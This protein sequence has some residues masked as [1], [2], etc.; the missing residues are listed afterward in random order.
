MGNVRRGW[1]NNRDRPRNNN[2]GFYEAHNNDVSDGQQRIIDLRDVPS[3]WPTRDG[4]VSPAPDAWRWQD[5]PDVLAAVDS[6][7][8][9]LLFNVQLELDGVRW[10]GRST[11]TRI[12]VLAACQDV[13][14]LWQ[15]PSAEETLPAPSNRR[16]VNHSRKKG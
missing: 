4:M 5:R 13:A 9:D 10:P 1:D 15:L 7:W 8:R 16:R 12:S 2:P 14:R 11:R 3:R 6:F